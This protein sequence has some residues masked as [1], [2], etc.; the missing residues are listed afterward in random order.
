M[1]LTHAAAG[2][3]HTVCLCFVVASLGE[4]AV[5]PR[6]GP[7]PAP[8]P[9]WSLG[10]EPGPGTHM[11]SATAQCRPWEMSSRRARRSAGITPLTDRGQQQCG[12]SASGSPR[13]TA[14]AR[15]RKKKR[16][17]RRSGSVAGAGGGGAMGAGSLPHRSPVLLSP[18]GG[19]AEQG[20]CLVALT[21]PGAALLRSRAGSG[22]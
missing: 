19:R 16:R 3:S 8:A 22:C 1:R 10:R 13:R 9:G 17:R 21:I 15:R 18:P 4:R 11:T 7:G 2:L 5:S 12:S 6:P 20:L 14:A